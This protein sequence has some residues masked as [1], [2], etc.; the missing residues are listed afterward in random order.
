ME[1]QKIVVLMGLAMIFPITIILVLTINI[2]LLAKDKEKQQCIFQEL[3]TVQDIRYKRPV[4]P[5]SK[6][7]VQ[8]DTLQEIRTMI[9]ISKSDNK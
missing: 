6:I 2:Y 8:H 3:V 7:K 4:R 5:S 1:A 9:G